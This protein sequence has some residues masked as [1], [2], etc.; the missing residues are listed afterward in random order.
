MPVDEDSEDF[1]THLHVED[2][3]AA[4]VVEQ[5]T[6]LATPLTLDES[7]EMSKEKVDI[8]EDIAFGK[9]AGDFRIIGGLHQIGIAD[10]GL[11]RRHFLL[12][13]TRKDEVVEV[14]RRPQTFTGLEEIGRIDLIR[15][16]RDRGQIRKTANCFD[17]DL[18]RAVEK[19]LDSFLATNN[20][21]ERLDLPEVDIAI[22]GHF[23]SPSELKVRKLLTTRQLRG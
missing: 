9:F 13:R 22:L 20:V 8:L 6:V 12:R 7:C 11:I 17:G 1:T 21:D 3:A 14:V 18:A 23:H 19:R 5:R 2:I 10:G 16:N 15:R 4:V